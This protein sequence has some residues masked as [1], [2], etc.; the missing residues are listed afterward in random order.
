[1]TQFQKDYD[2]KRSQAA[3][4]RVRGLIGDNRLALADRIAELYDKYIPL[5]RDVLLREAL[6]ASVASLTTPITGKPDK[7]R[8]V[9]VCGRSGAGKTTAVA[10]HVELS[11][12]HI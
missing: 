7:R 10:K 4:D 1:M 8:I 6:M 9:A 3:I 12:I 2:A 5:D 11:L